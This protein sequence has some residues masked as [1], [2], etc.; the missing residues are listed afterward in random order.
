VWNLCEVTLQASVGIESTGI[1]S[2]EKQ[3]ACPNN[4]RAATATGGGRGRGTTT[5]T[6]NNP[7]I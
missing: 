5:T 2:E 1:S 7:Q 3:I 4:T 6:D